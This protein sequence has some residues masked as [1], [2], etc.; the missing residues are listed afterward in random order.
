MPWML[1]CRRSTVRLP[2]RF[3]S[4]PCAQLVTP[5]VH[6]HPAVGAWIPSLCLCARAGHLMVLATTCGFKRTVG[7]ASTDTGL[8]AYGLRTSTARNEFLGAFTKAC[9]TSIHTGPPIYKMAL[10]LPL[11]SPII[12]IIT[13]IPLP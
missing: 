11:F 7:T 6:L 2:V 1:L 13:S 3:C 9:M 4:S 8:I 12:E 5:E 10:P